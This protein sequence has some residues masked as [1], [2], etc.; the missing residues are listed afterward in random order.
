MPYSRALLAVEG[1][2]SAEVFEARAPL[3]EAA[4]EFDR[5]GDRWG[6]A[7]VEFVWMDL[8]HAVGELADATHAD[9]A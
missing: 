9:R 3:T 2:G 1:I 4:A 6:Q 5:A 7:L 8:H